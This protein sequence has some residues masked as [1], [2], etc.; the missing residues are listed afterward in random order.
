MDDFTF[1]PRGNPVAPADDG[2]FEEV[3]E[4]KETGF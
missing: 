2:E 1:L 4:D 3:E